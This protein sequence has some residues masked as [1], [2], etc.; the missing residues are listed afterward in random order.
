[1]SHGPLP[2]EPESLLAPEPP[3]PELP[4]L[5][6]DPEVPMDPEA[7]APAPDRSPEEPLP[8]D[9]LEEPLC[10]PDAEPLAGPELASEPMPEEPDGAPEPVATEASGNPEPSSDGLDP[11]ANAA[12]VTVA[13]AAI[14][15]ITEAAEARTMT[16]EEFRTIDHPS[17]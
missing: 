7:A 11:Q 5:P 4:E 9:P 2:P 12:K 3:E 14:R 8:E 13:A 6:L 16:C 1:M 17:A 15:T 10:E